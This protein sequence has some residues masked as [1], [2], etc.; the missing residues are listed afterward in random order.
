MHD[1]LHRLYR[2]KLALLAVLLLFLG[3]ALLIFGHWITNQAS[4]HWLTNWPIIDIGS[5]MFTT[6]LLGVALQYVDGRDSEL[7]D[8]ERLKR[9]LAEATPA[10][11][12]A[13]INGF[14]FEP[15]DLARVATPEVLDQIVRNG[16]SLRLGDAGFARDIYDDLQ[17][18]AIAVPERLHDARISVHLSPL[19]MGRGTPNG[20]TPLFVVTVRWESSLHPKYRNRRFSAVSDIDEF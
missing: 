19:P 17:Q 2:T 7:R 20:R 16:L 10:M 8:T 14:A 1:T 5:G 3:L 4:W 15:D 12:D 9:V 13:V 11:R 18:Q 6:G